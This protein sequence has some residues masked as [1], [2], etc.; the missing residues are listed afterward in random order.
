MTILYHVN[1][2]TGKYEGHT[3]EALENPKYSSATHD[4][5]DKYIYDPRTASLIEPPVCG[6]DEVAVLEDSVWVKKIDKSGQ[7]Y[8][9][10]DGTKVEITECNID[11]P[12]D[13]IQDE[14]LSPYHDTHDGTN[15]IWN[16]EAH[17]AAR[18]TEVEMQFLTK[19]ED[20]LDYN[21]TPYQ[22]DKNSQESVTK[23]CVYAKC[24]NDDPTNFPWLTELQTW[25]DANNIDQ[26]FST[27]A[28]YLAFGKAMTEH[29]ASLYHK[30]Q[31]HKDAIRALATYETVRDY[32]ITI[33]W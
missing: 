15:W 25:R 21:G 8:Y 6:A 31:D 27:P 7:H 23:R 9:D 20:P 24:S 19:L 1:R 14:P 28:E 32:D 17:I 30:M 2:K 3:T 11:V 13:A 18:C 12:V 26:P 5:A 4:E 29:I 10:Q 16:S 33:N 22:K